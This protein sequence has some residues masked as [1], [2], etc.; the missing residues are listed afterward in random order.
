MRKNG[1]IR[2]GRAGRGASLQEFQEALSKR[3]GAAASVVQKDLRLGIRVGSHDWLLALPDAGEVI[4]VPAIT[5]V[6]RTKPWMLGLAN[7]RGRL[8]AVADLAAFFGETPTAIDPRA[9]LLLV[10]QRHGSNAAILVDR[11]LGLK[12]IAELSLL[13]SAED[14]WVVKQYSDAQGKSW[15]ELALSRLLSAEAFCAAAA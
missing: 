10:G 11:V 13:P 6:P 3:I 5:P 15:R 8:H 1:R 7:V 4:P 9:R 2:A 12:S 14:G